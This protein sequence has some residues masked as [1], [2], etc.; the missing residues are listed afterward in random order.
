[1]HRPSLFAAT[2]LALV[3]GSAPA[4]AE[5]AASDGEPAGYGGYTL[6]DE[7]DYE[8]DLRAASQNPVADLISL[9]IQNNVNFGVG[10]R[11]KTGWVT[12]V[13]PVIPFSLTDDINLITRTIVPVSRRP[14]FAPGDSGAFGIGDVNPALFLSPSD[15]IGFEGGQL[16]WGAGAAFLL[17][18]AT[19]S[20]LG[21]GKLA[22]GPSAVGLALSPPWV[23]GAIASNLWSVAG[24]DGRDDVNLFIVQPFVNYNLPDGWFLTA[25]PIIT[26]NWEA[27]DDRWTVPV[28]GGVGRVFPIGRQPVNMSLQAFGNVVSPDDIGPDWSIRFALTFL[29]PR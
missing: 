11:D 27:G 1:M 28:G 10:P 26:S 15:P 5:G 4:L 22:V 20:T 24:P 9:P 7:D 25:A 23:V 6:A 2:A 8:Q 21:T 29:F 17:P 12:N 18:T 16:V 14:S 19:D 3:L 13:Q